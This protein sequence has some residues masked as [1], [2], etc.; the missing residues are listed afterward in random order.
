MITMPSRPASVSPPAA[1]SF[2]FEPAESTHHF[3]VKVPASNRGFVE[4]SEHYAWT[5]ELGSSPVTLGA[6]VEDGQM[7]V[8]L[9]RTKWDAIADAARLELNAG[10]R[11]LA[12]KPG[13]WKTGNNLLLR[14]LGKELTLLAWAI[15]DADPALI[16]IAIANWVG[17]SPE[18]RW[19]MY[20][21]TAAATGNFIAG[22]NRGWRKAVRF[23]LTENP[24]PGVAA[25]RPTV[26]EFFR[27]VSETE[28][29][30]AGTSRGDAGNAAEPATDSED[31]TK[32]DE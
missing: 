4:I 9:P 28:P 1:G 23:A 10:L 3:L 6:E 22:R 30:W 14:T 18:E 5:A 29:L 21:M 15:E 7:R 11:K 32:D 25:D 24:A 2:G 8:R 31:S 19:W 17:L 16:P 20:T 13:K 12:K 26:P 27:L